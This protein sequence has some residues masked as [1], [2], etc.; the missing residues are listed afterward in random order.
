M[1]SSAPAPADP[2]LAADSQAANR[3]FSK[4]PTQPQSDAERLATEQARAQKVKEKNKRSAP[5]VALCSS[6]RV[7][8]CLPF[9][10][11]TK[12]PACS[13]WHC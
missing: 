1:L 4:A 2:G 12:P 9:W 7:S 11:P 10:T 5:M 6:H 8:P 13:L 3:N